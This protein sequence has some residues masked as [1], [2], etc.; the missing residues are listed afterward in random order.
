MRVR[1][2]ERT[3]PDLTAG[4]KEKAA[5][6]PLSELLAAILKTHAFHRAESSAS[7]AA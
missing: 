5:R 4:A 3:A 1:P 7:P 6:R 2:V